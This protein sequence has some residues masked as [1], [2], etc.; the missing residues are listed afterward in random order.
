MGNVI[1]VLQERSEGRADNRAL[2][3]EVAKRLA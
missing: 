2:S 1:K 3:S